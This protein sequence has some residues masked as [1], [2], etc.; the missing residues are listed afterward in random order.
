[1]APVAALS[2]ALGLSESAPQVFLQTPG[3]WLVAG[4]FVLLTAGVALVAFDVL[5]RRM[6]VIGSRRVMLLLAEAV[7]IWPALALWGH[8]EDVLGVA[9]AALAL[10]AAVDQKW[11]KAGWLMGAAIAVQLLSG[12][13]VPILAGMAGAGRRLPFLLRAAFLPGVLLAVFMIP[14]FHDTW[15]VL[16]QQPTYPAVDHPTP[17]VLVSP[18]IGPGMVAAGPAR[19]GAVVVAVGAGLIASRWR[20]DRRRLVWLAALVMAARC[21]FEAVMDP[22]YVMPAVTLAFIVAASRPGW[23]W[24]PT[25]AVGVTLTVVTHFHAGIWTYWLSMTA[26]L[27]ALLVL[28]FPSRGGTACARPD[29]A[30]PETVWRG[31]GRFLSNRTSRQV[32]R[33]L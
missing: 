26:L 23:R 14:D 29:V 4:P 8:P 27:A 2:S 19:I 10:A 33:T 1:M 17:W 32:G 21:I 28:A 20:D 30:P 7:A 15:K 13:I 12:L 6:G 25:L 9:A 31:A 24:I 3:A 22:Y 16:T 5:A 11:V 18:R